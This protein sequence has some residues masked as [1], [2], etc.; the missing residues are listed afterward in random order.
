ML[1]FFANY[2]RSKTDK[3]HRSLFMD[4]A[5]I[6]KKLRTERKEGIIE[7]LDD[8]KSRRMG[9]ARTNYIPTIAEVANIIKSIPKGQTRTITELRSEFA[10]MRDTDTSCPA[11]LLKYWKWMAN[12]SDELK[13]QHK[14]YDIPWWRV[15]KDGKPSRHMPGGIENQKKLLSSEGILFG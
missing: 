14:E 5:I 3:T 10:K 2:S 9:G 15:L 4:D 8:E 12:L 11:K 13:A 6:L 7:S 1:Y